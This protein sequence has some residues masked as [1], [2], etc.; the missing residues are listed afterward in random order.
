M[1]TAN[2]WSNFQHEKR[3]F[4]SASGHALSVEARSVLRI[5]SNNL[6]VAYLIDLLINMKL[7][8]V[9]PRII[10]RGNYYFFHI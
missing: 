4:R 2:K 8:T 3:K 7:I 10:A 5:M 9:F 6:E 1:S